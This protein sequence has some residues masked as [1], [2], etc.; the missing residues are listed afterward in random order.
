MR[1]R[2]HLQKTAA[3]IFVAASLFTVAAPNNRAEAMTVAPP[4]ALAPAAAAVNPVQQAALVCGYW[5][6]V[7]VWPYWH[8]P[9]WHR[10]YWSGYYRP[11][12]H[13]PWWGHRWGWGWHHAYW[14][15]RWGWGWHRH[16]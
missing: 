4:S 1:E 5:R 7:H 13:R 10:A 6:C 14:G 9:Y 8:R 15:H 16:W 12:W 11:Y 2:L 3:T